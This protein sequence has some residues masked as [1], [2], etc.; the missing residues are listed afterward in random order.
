V[1]QEPSPLP[2]AHSSRPHPQAFAQEKALGFTIDMHQDPESFARLDARVRQLIEAYIGAGHDDYM[3][4]T[5]FNDHH[6]VRHLIEDNE[7]FELMV[8]SS[9][10]VRARGAAPASRALGSS[11]SSVS[12][13][14]CFS[15]V[16]FVFARTPHARPSIHAPPF[17]VNPIPSTFKILCWKKGQASRV[18]NHA[19]SHGWLTPLSGEM[20]RP[21]G[22]VGG[23]MCV[24][25]GRAGAQ[26]NAA[27]AWLL[28]RVG[29]RARGCCLVLWA[30]TASPISSNSSRP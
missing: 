1:Q 4:Y 14:R 26:V 2:S 10:P 12:S 8:R 28:F 3:K 30:L 18:H 17:L 5:A 9:R 21:A 25:G 23:L 16:G 20:V 7:D 29:R 15:P 24:L 6:Y 27:R 19:T 13:K 22:R 11:L